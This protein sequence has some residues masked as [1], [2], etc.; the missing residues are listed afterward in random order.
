[1]VA[2]FNE[3]VVSAI[4]GQFFMISSSADHQTSDEAYN[5]GGMSICWLPEIG[6]RA[7]EGS[8]QN[9]SDPGFSVAQHAG[10][11]TLV[12]QDGCLFR[13]FDTRIQSS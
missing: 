10:S 11:P 4:P 6:G 7:K 1:M 2:S 9:A 8:L 5:T 13:R 12:S 3:K